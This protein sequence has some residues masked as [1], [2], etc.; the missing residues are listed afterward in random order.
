MNTSEKIQQARKKAGLTQKEL[1]KKLGCT[2]QNLA[3]YENGKRNPK[4]YTLCKIAD[5]LNISVDELAEMP[6]PPSL[7]VDGRSFRTGEELTKYLEHSGDRSILI[8]IFDNHLNEKG[9]DKLL[10]YAEDLTTIPKYQ[11][12]GENTHILVNAAHARTDIEVTEEMK[13]H[14]DDIMNDE[15]F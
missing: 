5:A 2:A 4:P 9:Q 7:K 6:T 3:Q 12:K 14:D 8:N 1:A 10:D 15:D 13:K 11:K